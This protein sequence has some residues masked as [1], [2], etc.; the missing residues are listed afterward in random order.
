M[1]NFLLVI[2]TL[3]VFMLISWFLWKSGF[4]TQA[5][6]PVD[7]FDRPVME[8]KERK[9]ILKRLKRWREE[10]KLSREEFEHLTA[11]CESE[12]DSRSTL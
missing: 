4:L 10:G 9:A 8:A 2:L 11:L 3:V 12:W 6:K 5:E 7:I 1:L